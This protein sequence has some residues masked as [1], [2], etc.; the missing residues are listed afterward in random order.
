M[1]FDRSAANKTRVSRCEGETDKMMYSGNSVKT[2]R[3]AS[4]GAISGEEGAM[5]FGSVKERASR[6]RLDRA[7]KADKKSTTVVNINISPDKSK[8]SAPSAPG[9]PDLAAML[10]KPPVPPMPAPGPMA[11]MAAP[12]PAPMPSGPG[13]MAPMGGPSVS[14]MGPGG[15][16]Q[17]FRRGGRVKG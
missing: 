1:K 2:Q 4:G 9:I 15:P 16:P 6:P 7:K 11:P 5:G 8:D 3:R 10:P 12:G 13:P 17:P 14:P